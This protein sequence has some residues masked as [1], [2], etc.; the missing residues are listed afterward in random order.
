MNETNPASAMWERSEAELR[1]SFYDFPNIPLHKYLGITFEREDPMGPA[2]CTLPAS[3]EFLW[4]DGR[5]SEAAI[6]TIGEVS[7]GVAV[8]DAVVPT[9]VKMGLRPVVLTKSADFRPLAPAYGWI[10]GTCEV[11][12]DYD[13]A[14]ER[15]NKRKK[16][17]LDIGVEIH[18]EHGTLVGESV[19][20]YYVRLMDSSRLQTMAAMAPGM[21]GFA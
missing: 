4:P 17:D 9:A 15:M 21:A 14:I 16:A 8:S 11:V 5:H 10:R 19:L 12:G 1:A 7:G 18:D 13:A 2:I 3:P 20:H 6:Y